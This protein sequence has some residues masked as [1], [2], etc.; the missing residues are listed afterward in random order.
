MEN[1]AEKK[2]NW[3]SWIIQFL[4]LILAG[5]L[6]CWVVRGI[7]FTHLNQAASCRVMAFTIL[8]GIAIGAQLILCAVR[9]QMLLRIQQI[10][11]PFLRALSLSMQGTFFSLCMPGGAVG[12][13]VIKAAFLLRETQK[14]KK[15]HGVT[16]IFIDRVI[17]MLALF[18]LVAAAVSF[19]M[20]RVLAFPPE[21]KYPVIILYLLCLAGL[22]AG[23]ALF[24]QDII[25][26]I[27]LARKCLEFADRLAKGRIKPVLE[28]VE[29]CRKAPGRLFATFLL[30]VLVMHPLLV[31]GLVLIVT[32]VTGTTA[33]T[34]GTILASLLGSTAAAIPITPGGLGTRDKITQM[35]LESQGISSTG[36]S[37]APLLYTLA[38]VLVSMTGVFFFLFD[39]WFRKSGNIPEN[40]TSK[41]SEK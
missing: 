3:K 25:F 13:D 17:G 4:K 30:S 37:F 36:A 22:A 14:G 20:K 35:V 26:R 6:I 11:I 12:G 10:E 41:E 39:S 21:V 2:R 24:L 19:A 7:D 27:P 29:C 32:G 8:A 34:G 28:S 38:L 16:S 5:I 33:H 31:L 9:W 18:F 23:A 15:L 40:K 1:N